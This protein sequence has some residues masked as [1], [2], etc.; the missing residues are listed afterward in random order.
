M[1]VGFQQRVRQDSKYLNNDTFFRLPVTGAQCINGTEN[2]PDA[3]IM[4]NSDNDVNSLG[5][6][7]IKGTLRAL[8]E[9]D[10]HKPFILDHDLRSSNVRFENTGY[11]K[12]VFDIR[13]QE[14][15]QFLNQLE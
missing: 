15:S 8:T 9:D 4:L 11:K 12:Y 7:Q 6:G 13:C 1:I 14:K 2:G 10:I 3:G 5:N